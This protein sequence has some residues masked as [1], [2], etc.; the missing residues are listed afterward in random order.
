MKVVPFDDF[1]VCPPCG[2]ELEEMGAFLN[3]RKLDSHESVMP[4]VKEVQVS[5]VADQT[6]DELRGRVRDQ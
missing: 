1:Q 2:K 5:A 3:R 6:G 4:K